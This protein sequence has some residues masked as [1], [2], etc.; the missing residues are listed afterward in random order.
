M[1]TVLCVDD[2]AAVGVVL[3]H[4][5]TRLGHTPVLAASV[6]EAMAAVGRSDIDLIIAD[7]VMPGSTGLDL[8]KL[9]AEQGHRIRSSS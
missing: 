1:A 7:Y 3:E 5:L 2:E 8:L 4:T 6:A 9:L